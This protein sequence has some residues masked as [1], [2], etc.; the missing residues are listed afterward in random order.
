MAY[1]HESI[2]EAVERAGDEC[3]RALIAHHVDTPIPRV[4]PRRGMS[5]D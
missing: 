5:V 3:W 1:T 4:G 2:R